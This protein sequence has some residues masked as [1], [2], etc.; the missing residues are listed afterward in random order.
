MSSVSQQL[1]TSE[2]R[3]N[4]PKAVFFGGN[5][6]LYGRIAEYLNQHSVELFAGKNLSDALYG[7]YYF[8][9]GDG[10]GV[11][12]FIVDNLEHLPKTLLLLTSVS[13]NFFDLSNTKSKQL[14]KIVNISGLTEIDEEKTVHIMDFFLGSSQ[15]ELDLSVE[16]RH[17]EKVEPGLAEPTREDQPLSVEE[18]SVTVERPI[19]EATRPKIEPKNSLI[20]NELQQPLPTNQPIVSET[21]HEIVLRGKKP[22]NVTSNSTSVKP[23]VTVKKALTFFKI[24][25]GI[26]IAFIIL[27]SFFLGLSLLSAGLSLNQTQ[28]SITQNTPQTKTW[29]DISSASLQIA[30][31]SSQVLQ[32]TFYLL[33]QDAFAEQLSHI[34]SMGKYLNHGGQLLYQA[35]QDSQ[36]VFSNSTQT[37]DFILAQ[38]VA[39]TKSNLYLANTELALAEAELKSAKLMELLEK[40][41]F[42]KDTLLVDKISHSLSDLRSKTNFASNILTLVPQALGFSGKRTYLV[43][44]QNNMELRPTGGFV[45]SFG[46]VEVNGGKSENFTV[47]DVY[48][49]D[50]ALQGHIEPPEPIK[51]YLHQEHW[52]MRDGNWDP[53]FPNSAQKMLWFLEKEIG[54]KADG[55][56][57]VD[58]SLAEKL[59][60]LTGPVEV[61]DFNETITQDNLFVKTHNLIETNFFPGSTQKKDF[62]SSFARA[63]QEKLLHSQISSM[64]MF[65][66]VEQAVLQKHLLIYFLNPDAQKL[67]E[68][69]DWGGKMTVTKCFTKSCISDYLYLVDANLGVNKADF[70]TTKEVQDKLSLTDGVF[71]H[72]ITLIYK[73]N[74]PAQE[75][76][77]SGVYRDYIR[78]YLPLGSQV[79]KAEINNLPLTINLAPQ[80]LA[81]SAAVTVENN[82][83]T[84]AIFNEILPNS[85]SIIKFTYELP[86]AVTIGDGPYEYIYKIQKQPGTDAN[87][88]SFIAQPPSGWSMLPMD[89]ELASKYSVLD[90]DQAISYNTSLLTDERIN[91]LISQTSAKN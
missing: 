74:S 61:G 32:P 20:K 19:P 39:R 9:F 14:I 24:I 6:K 60:G 23:F 83:Q 64:E 43:L 65:D 45:G 44:L 31:I 38:V 55:V 7:D 27:P 75:D 67:V 5:E 72:D 53:D 59:V 42:G 78:A 84:L 8:Y 30:K 89:N 54:I 16:K 21:G 26:F 87:K 81:S 51:I 82:F 3:E 4:S 46:L 70:Y 48:S 57:G 58:L 77:I 13:D 76:K 1:T 47:Q 62:L 29:L 71:R 25:I 10:S 22:N 15:P 12:E 35:A 80:A 34:I 85:Q 63:L 36:A 18:S 41:K 2:T 40:V 28:K 33:K 88:F 50:G 17:L 69:Y 11:K 73:N 66:L 56:I 79:I 68:E 49:A 91:L 37:Q 86:Q 52:Y 90:K